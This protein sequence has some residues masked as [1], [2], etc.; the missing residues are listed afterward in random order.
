MKNP[1]AFQFY[2]ND[3]ISDRKVVTMSLE[4]RGMYITLLCYCWQNGGE[5]PDDMNELAELCVTDASRMRDAW[6]RRLHRCFERTE[7][8]TLVNPRMLAEMEKQREH[9]EKRSKSAKIAAE[10]RW[11]DARRMRDACE[12]HTNRIA[13]ASEKNANAS[14]TQCDSM[15]LHTSYFI[16]HNE[17]ERKICA[18]DDAQGENLIPTQEQ[19]ET[20]PDP[21]PDTTA[22]DP[23]PETPLPKYSDDFEKWWAIY[24]NKA[25]KNAAWKIW[26][27]DKLHRM[28]ELIA[29][30]TLAYI[31]QHERSIA[32][33]RFT[34]E[35][36]HGSTFL[37]K[38]TYNDFVSN[39]GT[40]EERTNGHGKKPIPEQYRNVLQDIENSSIRRLRAESYLGSLD[41]YDIASI[42]L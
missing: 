19:E 10:Q 28:R 8:G 26:Q 38:K 16:L 36:Q 5:L 20:Q 40:I 37:S 17:E 34:P 27:R 11:G 33:G 18:S 21:V 41:E 22:P 7:N 29:G 30:A 32:T 12:S 25:G 6:D 2:V 15:P 3:F 31:D 1:P 39:T 42:G 35:Y 23:I 13:N 9:R 24:P 14:S 4:E